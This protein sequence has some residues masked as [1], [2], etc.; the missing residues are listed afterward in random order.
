VVVRLG[1][2]FDV[3]GDGVVDVQSLYVQRQ[4]VEGTLVNLIIRTT[5]E[6]ASVATTHETHRSGPKRGGAN[7]GI[8][9]LDH[10]R[11]LPHHQRQGINHVPLHKRAE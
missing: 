7:L 8:S 6:R 9:Q 2:L 10:D 4:R 1:G 5:E 3:V 11:H